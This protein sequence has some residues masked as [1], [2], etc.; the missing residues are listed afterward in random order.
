MRRASVPRGAHGPRGPRG[1]LSR[2]QLPHPRPRPRPRPRSHATPRDQRPEALEPFAPYALRA[3]LGIAR[4]PEPALRRQ[5]ALP[6]ERPFSCAYVRHKSYERRKKQERKNQTRD[7]TSGR[8][9][10]KIAVKS[11]RK[12]KKK[13]KSKRASWGARARS[14]PHEARSHEQARDGTAALRSEVSHPPSQRLH[15]RTLKSE[16][17][18]TSYFAHSRKEPKV[19]RAIH[20]KSN[21]QNEQRRWADEN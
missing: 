19:E 16:N 9:K 12:T 4:A 15:T 20:G 1:R 3:G 11:P 8:K 21:T 13:G 6:A 10:K 2:S 5:H 18:N 7:S 14:T 17:N